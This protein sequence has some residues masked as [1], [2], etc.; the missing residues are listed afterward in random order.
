MFTWVYP[1][2]PCAHSIYSRGVAVRPIRPYRCSPPQL[3]GGPLCVRGFTPPQIHTNLELSLA[4]FRYNL[5]QS[6]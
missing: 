2:P 1:K 5:L 6:L 3:Q 4:S